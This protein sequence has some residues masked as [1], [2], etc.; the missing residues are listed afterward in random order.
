MSALQAG[1][2][3]ATKAQSLPLA[4]I[5]V[6]DLTQIYNGPYCTFMMAQAGAEVIKIEPP[7]GETLRSR[8]NVLPFVMLNANKQSM[9]LNLKKPEGRDLLLSL[10]EKADVVVENFTP[11]VMHRLGVG[12]EALSKRNPRIIYG[13]SSGFGSSGPYC[14]YPAMDV[15]IQAMSGVISITGF[16]DG[17]P[18]KAGPAICDIFGGVHLYGAIMTALVER[19]ITGRGREVEV[20]M[21]DATIFTLASHLGMYQA[22]GTATRTGNRHGGMS[23]APYSVYPA[24]DGYLAV[25]ANNERDWLNFLKGMNHPEYGDDPR[26][27]TIKDRS[28]NMDALDAL[29]STWTVLEDKQTLFKRLAGLSIPC[30]PIQDIEEVVNDPHLQH[31]GMMQWREHP[32]HG[33]MPLPGS[34]LVFK[35]LERAEYVPSRPLGADTEAILA[36]RLG[37]DAASI[38]ALRADGV[39]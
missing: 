10:A 20:A 21:L 32:Q 17:P 24:S 3:S 8:P 35:G 2:S 14:D 22:T 5:T 31:R 28:K 13:S 37:L 6:L 15:V 26:F 12:Y 30:A 34:P 9:V 19:S 16:P 27:L 23:V 18:I 25:M 29:I 7:G 38:S 33:R 11:G 4:G 1:A 36:R 39:I